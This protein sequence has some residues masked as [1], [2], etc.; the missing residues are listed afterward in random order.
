MLRVPVKLLTMGPL[1]WQLHDQDVHFVRY[2]S[3][4][5]C[6]GAHVTPMCG[7]LVQCAPILVHF[8]FLMQWEMRKVSHTF[9][10]PWETHFSTK[11]HTYPVDNLCLS[12]SQTPIKY[13]WNF[14]RRDC[15]SLQYERRQSGS[16][17]SLLAIAWARD[18]RVYLN[19]YTCVCAISHVLYINGRILRHFRRLCPNL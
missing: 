11:S 16:I 14:V 3:C 13:I 8:S 2:G 9:L 4:I 18:T 6:A 10:K 15:I 17:M 12:V 1:A 19:G 7:I 5:P